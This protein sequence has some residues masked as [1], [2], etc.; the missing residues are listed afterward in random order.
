MAK[1]PNVIVKGK[2][3]S[4]VIIDCDGNIECVDKEKLGGRIATL[5]MKRQAAGIAISKAL[6]AAG[7]NVC[8]QQE[9]FVLDSCP[10]DSTS[11]KK[12]A[13]KSRK[14]AGKKK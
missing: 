4:F 11:A 10:P 12:A 6:G 3:G 5:M 13:K 1:G 9:S 7:F 14:K 2:R 8:T